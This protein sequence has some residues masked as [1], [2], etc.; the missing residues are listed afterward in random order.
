M[1]ET[2]VA[3]APGS[4]DADADALAACLAHFRER[5]AQASASSQPLQL[6]GGGTKCWYGGPVQGQ[7]LDTRAYAGV[8]AY[9]PAELVITAR[10]GTPLA[11]LEA[12][13]AQHGQMLAFEPPHFGAHAT[14]GGCVAA[15][16]A[17]PRRAQVGA[18]RDFL[19]GAVVM[20]GAG[21][22][23][24]FG[25]QVMKNV[26]GYDVARL[27]PGA[28]GTLGLLLELSLKVLPRPSAHASL[29]FEMSQSAALDA[30][31]R[32]AGQ[33]LPISASAWCD[34]VLTLRLEGAQAAVAAA[35]RTLG[36]AALDDDAAASYWHGL[37]EQHAAFF[38]G[39]ADA[40]EP[41]AAPL[42][43]V[44]DDRAATSAYPPLWRISLP[45]A[46]AP[47]PELG[48]QLIEWGGAQRWVYSEQPA[49]TLRA[50][51]ARAGG[52]ATLFRGG[53][54]RENVF[55]PLAAPLH[56]IHLRLKAAF[57]PAHIFNR[58]RLYPD[59]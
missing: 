47:L 24:H 3:A 33:P 27:M 15:G 5:I 18:I 39:S 10:C 26:A 21:E 34:E 2:P 58:A 54:R 6:Q 46:T 4:A 36:G 35:A 20:N 37:R 57:D 7:V 38:V 25:G 42:S 23:L 52:H 30:L 17:G 12:L 1:S 53:A 43:D 55:T 41:S 31:N 51:A 48:R 56:A 40:A 9:D 59:F 16:L 8:I 49:A 11:Q 50:A 44:S 13:L 14:L 45:A 19:L 28:L 22:V 32:W 29:R